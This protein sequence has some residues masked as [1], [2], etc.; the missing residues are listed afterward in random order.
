[1]AMNPEERGIETLVEALLN[2][3]Q[4]HSPGNDTPLEFEIGRVLQKIQVMESLNVAGSLSDDVLARVNL[5]LQQAV[6]EASKV[7]VE[8][9]RTV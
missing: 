9:H 1:M 6:Q 7:A 5:I 2:R 4:G 3:I 8:R